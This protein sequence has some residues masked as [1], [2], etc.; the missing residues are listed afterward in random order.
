M[1]FTFAYIS[2]KEDVFNTYLK[3]S[4]SNIL[5]Y[6]DIITKTD[7]LPS[8]FFNQVI[9]ESKNMVPLQQSTECTLKNWL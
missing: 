5:D 8:L 3:N 6:V 7:I 4:L 9:K 1:I 2:H